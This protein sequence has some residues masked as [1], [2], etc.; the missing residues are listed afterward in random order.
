MKTKK[1]HPTEIY[2]QIIDLFDDRDILEQ[3]LL[4]LLLK[5]GTGDMDEF[6]EGFKGVLK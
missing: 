1:E 4:H 6:I 3:I 2:Q 5:E